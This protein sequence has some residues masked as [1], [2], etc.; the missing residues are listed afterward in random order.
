LGIERCACSWAVHQKQE[1]CDDA[2][3]RDEDDDGYVNCRDNSCKY[4]EAC[5]EED[6][7]ESFINEL[8]GRTF[9]QD[10]GDQDSDET[11][12]YTVS[13]NGLFYPDEDGIYTIDIPKEKLVFKNVEMV[14]GSSYGFYVDED[15]DGEPD[16]DE[17]IELERAVDIVVEKESSIFEYELTPG[18]NFVSF[19]FIP[20]NKDSHEL[21]A[22]L[23]EGSGGAPIVS[24][25]RYYSG[26]E[27]SEYRSDLEDPEYG[28]SFPVFPGWGYV[29]RAFQPTTLRISGKKV[30]EPVG[31]VFPEGGWYLVG[32]HGSDKSYTAESLLDGINEVGS[33][34]ADNVTEW[35]SSKSKYNGLTK[36]TDEN[37]GEELYG[38][39][40]PIEDRLSYFVR[41]TEADGSTW[42]PE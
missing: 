22:E 38:F 13:A 2:E 23:N 21:L 7:E 3:E 32:V 30:T 15:E 16:P 19:P 10:D 42:T 1:V 12:E 27:V 6:D 33:F 11:E 39:D 14:A 8:I 41:L 9:A 34:T 25:A 24:I 35:D 37:D 28:P 5:M 26:F 40:F 18:Y 20:D 31:I 36:I 4:H 29:I 17:I